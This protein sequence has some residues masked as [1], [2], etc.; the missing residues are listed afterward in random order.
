[1]TRRLVLF[2]L[3]SLLGATTGVVALSGG[4]ALEPTAG[5]NGAVPG[6][7]FKPT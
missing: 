3:L 1:M 6:E 2:V 7:G 5:G 4:K